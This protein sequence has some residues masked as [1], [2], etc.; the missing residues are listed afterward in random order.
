MTIVRFFVPGAPVGKGRPI[1]GMKFVKGGGRLPSLRTPEKT[2]AYEGLVAHAGHV[3]MA[4]RPLLTGPVSM[5]VRIDC[6]MPKSFSKAKRA[7][8]LAGTVRP[9]T[10]PDSSNVLKGLEDGLNGVVWVDDVQAVEHVVSKRYAET[11]GVT[12]EIEELT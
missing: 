11:P 1:A 8:A 5:V 3:A 10:K 7:A 4:G 12:V 6:Q 2:V 9:T